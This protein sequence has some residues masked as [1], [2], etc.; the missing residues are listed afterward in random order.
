[1]KRRRTIAFTNSLSR[2]CRNPPKT[3]VSGNMSKS[4]NLIKTSASN[5]KVWVVISVSVVG[6][7][8]VA[9]TLR[10]RRK[11][12]ADGRVDFGAFI[13]RFELLPFPQLPP[14]AAAQP[15]AGLTFAVKDKLA[16]L[17]THTL[18]SLS[19]S[20]FCTVILVACCDR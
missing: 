12:K 19:L 13:E 2:S 9:E 7:V 20:L 10:R 14:P 17:L 15:L 6:I 8:V 4:L 16:F 11:V 18:P 5:P 1:M 3:R